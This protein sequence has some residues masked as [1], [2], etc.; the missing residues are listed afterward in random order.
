[1]SVVQNPIIGRAKGKYSTSVFSK[2][3]NLNILRSKA[4]QINQPNSAAQLGRRSLFGYCC[5]QIRSIYSVLKFS[6]KKSSVKFSPYNFAVKNLIN[7]AD[8]VS[9][10]FN[11]DKIREFPFS[12]GSL[13][14]P[15]NP[16]ITFMSVTNMR[17]SWAVNPAMDNS[18]DDCIVVGCFWLHKL[19]KLVVSPE[20][21][22]IS[23]LTSDFTVPV[24][25]ENEAV[26]YFYFVA[27]PDMKRFS[28]SFYIGQQ[29]IS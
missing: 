18:Y 19:G 9:L 16:S 6:L 10:E 12:Q 8:P 1:M 24:V 14:N 5:S 13:L 23:A 11:L 17:I 25:P 20:R 2:W 27:S 7:C 4:L 28:D 3:K 29:L 21:P 26:Q 22:L 15:I